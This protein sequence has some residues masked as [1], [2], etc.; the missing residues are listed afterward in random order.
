MALRIAIVAYQGVLADESHGFRD[1]FRRVPSADVITVGEE[2]GIVAGPGGVQVVAATFRDVRDIDVIVVPGGLGSHRHREI[3]WWILAAEPS[4]V[5]TSSTGS[6]LLAA[7]GL[8]RGRVAATH[9]LAGPLLERY[10]ARVGG[11]R[12]VVD[13][14]FVTC[15]GRATTTDA[16]LTVIGRIGGPAMVAAVRQSLVTCPPTD[17]PV[18]EST[19]RYRPRRGRPTPVPAPRQLPEPRPVASWRARRGR[20]VTEV[21][22]DDT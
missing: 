19:S 5:V 18:C 15:S 14:P 12:I 20:A 10:G 9:W 8:L 17:E 6:A 16:A 7:S 3:G 22:L 11:Q 1:V 13:E 2:I 21:D 4:W